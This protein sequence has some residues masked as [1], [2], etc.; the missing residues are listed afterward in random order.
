MNNALIIQKNPASRRGF[1][2]PCSQRTVS[3]YVDRQGEQLTGSVYYSSP[4]DPFMLM[5]RCTQYI[6]NGR[7][8]DSDYSEQRSL[9]L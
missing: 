7:K 6:L 1:L 8:T 2:L 4:A 5:L 3:G 9:P